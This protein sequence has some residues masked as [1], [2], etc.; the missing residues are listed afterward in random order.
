MNAFPAGRPDEHRPEAAENTKPEYAFRGQSGHTLSALSAAFEAQRRAEQQAT[1]SPLEWPLRI[2]AFF[3]STVL[4]GIPVLL[5]RRHYLGRGAGRKAR[6]WARW[7][8]FGFAFYVAVSV[9]I[10]MLRH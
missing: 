1:E 5:A 7:G 6:E 9:L 8:L 4:L 3:T 2:V 10:L